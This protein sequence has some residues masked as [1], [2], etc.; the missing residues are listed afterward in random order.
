MRL[1]EEQFSRLATMV[2]EMSEC[3]RLELS[4]V[5]VEVEDFAQEV[6]LNVM[7][8]GDSRFD[9]DR[10]DMPLFANFLIYRHLIDL[11]RK[12]YAKKHSVDG[13]RV[14]CFF[15]GCAGGWWG[16]V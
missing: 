4:A 13:K 8:R 7:M 15:V 10:T 9:E 5:D 6:M 11:R 12:Y 1:S 3:R 16:W 14:R 2:R